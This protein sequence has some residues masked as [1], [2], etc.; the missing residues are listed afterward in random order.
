MPRGRIGLPRDLDA[1]STRTK[2]D[3]ATLR[4]AELS[5][6]HADA[7]WDSVRA[8]YRTGV[9]PAVSLTIRRRGHVVVQGAI[10]HARGNGPDDPV[11]A[12][13]PLATPATPFGLFSASKAVT[14][15]VVH[16]L[17][18]RGALNSTIRS[19]STSRASTATAST[20]SPSPTC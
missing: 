3:T 18:E 8:L 19:A 2:V 16:L 14:A 20:G 13:A 10:G 15:I 1:V 4:D 5:A 6:A 17:V 7:I 9:H 11:S 12:P